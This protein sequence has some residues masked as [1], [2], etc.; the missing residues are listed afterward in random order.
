MKISTSIQNPQFLSGY[1]EPK[2]AK[3]RVLQSEDG[4][5]SVGAI[6]SVIAGL[7]IAAIIG[8][9][10]Y[11]K[12]KKIKSSKGHENK[13]NDKDKFLQKEELHSGF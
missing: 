9:F 3:S 5:S 2:F 7:I 10:I 12:I 4:G 11:L 13:P 6:I 8:R 1:A